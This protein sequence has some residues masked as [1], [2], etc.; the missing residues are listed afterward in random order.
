ME[1]S[2]YGVTDDSIEAIRIC[3]GTPGFMLISIIIAL[4]II[5]VGKKYYK[6]R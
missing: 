2:P 1:A 4:F 5:V 6:R 3:E